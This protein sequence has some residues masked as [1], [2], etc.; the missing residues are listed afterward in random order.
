[1][2]ARG[3][4]IHN[5]IQSLGSCGAAAARLL[6]MLVAMPDVTWHSH[7]MWCSAVRLDPAVPYDIL[8]R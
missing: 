8:T 7:L 1:M 6:D 2:S 3:T 5:V 4:L